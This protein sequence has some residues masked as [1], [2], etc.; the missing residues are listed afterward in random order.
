MVCIENN[1]SLIKLVVTASLYS[2]E[3]QIL[4]SLF[5]NVEMLTSERLQFSKKFPYSFYSRKFPFQYVI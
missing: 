1:I 2:T 3:E 4:L 5:Q